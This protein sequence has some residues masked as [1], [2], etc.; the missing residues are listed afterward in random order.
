MRRAR[1]TENMYNMALWPVSSI[2]RRGT[3]HAAVTIIALKFRLRGILDRS[4]QLVT[5]E[6]KQL[7]E[8]FKLLVKVTLGLQPESQRA[9]IPFQQIHLRYFIAV[10]IY[11][12]NVGLVGRQ[13]HT[14]LV[15]QFLYYYFI[16]YIFY[17]DIM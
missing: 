6:L 7:N 15:P 11:E 14:T 8:K 13:L 16:F 1:V 12:F 2:S 3:P 10:L 17:M 4:G 9:C 5:F